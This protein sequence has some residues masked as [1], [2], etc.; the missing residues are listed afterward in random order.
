MKRRII[1]SLWLIYRNKLLE[2]DSLINQSN[3]IKGN[4]NNRL[5]NNKIKRK[6]N[7]KSNNNKKNKKKKLVQNN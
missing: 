1:K 7:N 2:L 5:N 3:K 4:N 6:I